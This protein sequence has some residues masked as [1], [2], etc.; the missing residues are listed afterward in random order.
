MTQPRTSQST[1]H[2]WR[3]LGAWITTA[4]L[5]AT[6]VAIA[7]NLTA[8]QAPAAQ[9][10]GRG[11]SITRELPGHVN[12]TFNSALS[13]V[14]CGEIISLNDQ[15][16]PGDSFSNVARVDTK[17]LELHTITLSDTYGKK[18]SVRIEIQRNDQGRSG[19]NRT[20]FYD[21]DLGFPLYE[22]SKFQ[23]Y[24]QI[25]TITWE[26]NQADRF[27][28]PDENPD[29]TS[30]PGVFMDAIDDT[31]IDL[32]KDLGLNGL[33]PDS[34][35]LNKLHLDRIFNWTDD[36]KKEGTQPYSHLSMASVHW[37]PNVVGQEA[38]E[39]TYRGDH[40]TEMYAEIGYNLAYVAR[41][42]AQKAGVI[43]DGNTG[44]TPEPVWNGL[45]NALVHWATPP[46]IPDSVAD[47][48]FQHQILLQ[49]QSA[50]H[51]YTRAMAQEDTWVE[52][53]DLEPNGIQATCANGDAATYA[54]KYNSGGAPY[55]N[56]HFSGGT[57]SHDQNDRT[58]DVDDFLGT[59]HPPE[60]NQGTWDR[61]AMPS[62][63]V[64]TE[65]TTQVTAGQATPG[66][67]STSQGAN[68]DFGYD[69][70]PSGAPAPMW[71]VTQPACT[72]DLTLGADTDPANGYHQG[73]TNTNEF[74]AQLRYAVTGTEHPI[75]HIV[76]SGTGA[77]S[78]GVTLAKLFDHK[79]SKVF[80]EMEM[81]TV[82]VNSKHFNIIPISMIM[83][84]SP[85]QALTK[86][87]SENLDRF[88][89]KN[90]NMAGLYTSTGVWGNGSAICNDC[91]ASLTY[92]MRNLAID[93]HS[94]WIASRGSRIWETIVGND[95]RRI[96][97]PTL[98]P[99]INTL[100]AQAGGGNRAA[101]ALL[102]NIYHVAKEGDPDLLMLGSLRDE[103]LLQFLRWA[104]LGGPE[105]LDHMDKA[106]RLATALLQL[107]V[108]QAAEGTLMTIAEAL[109]FFEKNEWAVPDGLVAH[110]R[111]L[112]QASEDVRTGLETFFKALGAVQVA[113][114]AANG[115]PLAIAAAVV[116]VLDVVGVEAPEWVKSLV[117]L[118]DFTMDDLANHTKNYLFDTGVGRVA[119]GVA[120]NIADLKGITVAITSNENHSWWE[121]AGEAAAD[122]VF[123]AGTQQVKKSANQL[124][125]EFLT[126]EL[127]FNR[128]YGGQVASW[129]FNQFRG[130]FAEGMADLQPASN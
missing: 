34:L 93:K 44:A 70:T 21:Q 46:G 72:Q 4:T 73:L 56:Y 61:L 105:T 29:S 91:W 33:S 123:K 71:Q 8:C 36:E 12:V 10:Q 50:I 89:E 90:W 114:R 74:L 95:S 25:A 42:M 63:D 86:D 19:V 30:L 110:S 51:G 82:E 127:P 111:N 88:A 38:C 1:T 37:T 41:M 124:V 48:E 107:R 6:S 116:E 76:L 31:G 99:H 62:L 35:G 22:K 66:Q 2:P 97:I 113:V 59:D 79:F 121:S 100:I 101:T 5:A 67:A 128:H 122:Y 20:Y 16:S 69:G 96:P 83:E 94:N 118:Q 58:G 85:F 103:T 68:G 9:L 45:S 53:G 40:A 26:G 55:L 106:Q 104:D 23:T 108:T 126:R 130:G 47:T 112:A 17:S 102:E 81:P 15:F 92:V 125:G 14:N 24:K 84:A 39:T 7:G 98:E 65:F 80:T 3:R 75:E 57:T 120:T 28:H 77:G 18:F 52:Y 43:V 27:V 11:K 115:D 13:E 87:L 54:V 32:S 129:A 119:Q 109:D 60:N 78:G 117:G 64:A 49:I